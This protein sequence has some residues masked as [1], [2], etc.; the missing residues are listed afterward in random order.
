MN[1]FN[2]KGELNAGSV[3]EALQSIAKIAAVLEEN[4]PS[5]VGLAGPVSDSRRDE[6]ISQALMTQ[7]GKV[8]LAQ[9]MA[10]PIN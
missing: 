9:A 7:E 3:K 1:M 6:L 10:N 2:G 4:V 8:A 5:N